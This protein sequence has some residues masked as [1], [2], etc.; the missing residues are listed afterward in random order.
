VVRLRL[1]GLA[2]LAALA[3]SSARATESPRWPRWPTE[4][5]RAAAPLRKNGDRVSPDPERVD[6]VLALEAFA[7]PVIE[8]WIL[9]AIDDPATAVRRE[10]LRVCYERE[11]AACIAP[12]TGLWRRATEPTL[13]IAALRVV[14]LDP[15]AERL[16]LLLAAL[17]EDNDAMRGQAAQIL[18]WAPTRGDGRTRVRDA[19]VAKLGDMSALVRQ[20]AVESLGVLGDR[21]ATL[22]IARLLEDHEPQVQGAAAHA[23]GNLGDP[24]AA[25]ALLRL[26]AAPNEPP[27]LRAALAALVRLPGERVATGLL[28]AFDEPPAGLTT[29]EVADLIGLR[30]DPEDTLVQG[31]VD[32]TREPGNARHALRSLVL[33]GVPAQAPLR[34]ALRDR[35]LSPDLALEAERALAAAN[36]EVRPGAAA[37][38]RPSASD[39]PRLDDT[40]VDRMRLAALAVDAPRPAEALVDRAID[41][42]LASPGAITPRLPE[43]AA[44]A[45]ATKATG[46]GRRSRLPWAR[47]IGWA[48]D[49]ARST[50]QRCLSVLALGVVDRRAP[51]HDDATRSVVELL[52][53][54]DPTVRACAAASAPRLSRDDEVAELGLVDPDSRVR[55]MAILAAWTYG[56]STAVRRRVAVLAVD[57]PSAEVRSAARLVLER[58]RP[59]RR[60]GRW[61]EDGARPFPWA[62]SSRPSWLGVELDGARLWVPALG[63]GGRRFA[64]APGLTGAVTAVE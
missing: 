3:G 41:A 34:A 60:A 42:A 20:Q 13:R 52:G 25:L 21:E 45:V 23:L 29:L 56:T 61:L 7:T 15:Q 36:A 58:P 26:V 55:T 40:V 16:D 32:R 44:L 19:L 37:D 46:V 38:E 59:R 43:L 10:A 54:A 31:L 14:A 1:V 50:A 9:L 5:D 35:R 53:D 22:P 27:V 4:V 48:R 47:V 6:A 12:A 62:A 39:P 17:R 49:P 30:D 8:P 28:A 11:I 2:V 51:A 64:I 57:D 24:R 33:L 18:G 63:I